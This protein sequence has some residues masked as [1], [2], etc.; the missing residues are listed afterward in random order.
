MIKRLIFLFLIP[1]MLFGRNFGREYGD[2]AYIPDT[3]QADTLKYTRVFTIDDKEELRVVVMAND[4]SVAGL[5]S[6][7]IYFD[8]GYQFG[9]LVL[10]SSGNRDTAWGDRIQIDSMVL[11]SFGKV[12]VGTMVATGVLTSYYGGADTSAVSGYAVKV[13][14]IAMDWGQVWGS[15]IRFWAKGRARNRKGKILLL[16]FDLKYWIRND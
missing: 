5:T 7:S 10:N 6:D 2:T 1:A 14:R 12:N 9:E 3:L 11:D 15:Y 13:R 8:Y 16:C 4:T